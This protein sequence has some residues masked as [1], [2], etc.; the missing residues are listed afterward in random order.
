VLCSPWN[1][2]SRFGVANL[3]L[4]LD[5]P[6]WLLLV[7]LAV[8][9]VLA[10]RHRVLSLWGWRRDLSGALRVLAATGFAVAL[11]QPSL[12]VGD[13]AASV[14]IAVDESA[15]LTPAALA[16][17]Q[18]WIEQHLRVR[19]TADRV[20]LIAFAGDVR[21]VQPLTTRDSTPRLPDPA[22]LHPERTNLEA[23]LRTA[24]AMLRG[25]S[26]PR[27]I[28]LSDG[29]STAGDVSSALSDAGDVPVDVVPLAAPPRTP[30]VQLE[31]VQTPPYVR[32]GE[33][34]DS[35]VTLDATQPTPAHLQVAVDGQPASEQDVQL[36]S[37]QNHVTV[38]STE[39]D[40]GFHSI[41]VRVSGAPDTDA[42]NNVGFAFTVVKPKPR[43]MVI[44]E[45][46]DEGAAIE[47]MLRRAQM[48]VDVRPPEGLG[49]LDNLNPTAAV[50]LNNV[51]ATSLTLDQQKTL[52]SY[53]SNSGRGLVVLGGMTSYALG[54][55]SE[56]TLED[57]LPVLAQPP[58]KREGAQIAL[59]LV[60]DRSASM[61]LDSGG[62]TRLGMAKEAAILT[63]GALKPDDI[64][65]VMAF[66]RTNHWLVRPDSLQHLSSQNISDNISS[67]TAEGGTGLFQALK[68]AD[69]VLRATPADLKEMVLVDDGQAEDVKYD[70]LV[71]K[72]HQDK[73]GLSIVSMGDDV[74]TALMSKLARMGEGR[75]YQTARLRDIP[76][77][78]TQEA[79]LAK[80]A[81]LVEGTIQ[82]QLLTPSPM[83]RGIVPSAIPPLSG[84]IA[85]TPK[86]AAEVI[87]ASDEGTPLLAQWHYGL[88]RAV[89]WTSDVGT[90]W[91]TGWSG[92]DQNARFW[93]Q[94]VRWAMG[95]PIDR[96]F[97]ID[98]TRVGEEAHLTFEDVQDS[99]F[100]DR[101][102]L[103]LTVTSPDGAQSQAPLRQDAAGRYSATIL[104]SAPGAY[105]MDV[106]E[107]KVARTASRS[108]T[109]GFVVPPEAETVSFVAN[110]QVLRRIASETGGQLR[111]ASSTADMYP[112]DRATNA[113]RWDP[114]WPLFAVLALAAF[115][116]DVAVRRLRPSTLRALLGRSTISRGD[117][118]AP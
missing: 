96:D 59:V 101:Q 17:A 9:A 95:P 118:I 11:A 57:V 79:A 70:D 78:I 88:G 46:P 98:V 13:D 55:Y 27:V 29:Q 7:P 81:A 36:A 66:D 60:I 76:R 87:L 114:V 84:Q 4:R 31:S 21:I 99:Q 108:E 68:E 45:R 47:N 10:T 83:L 38:S 62:V 34:F 72:I 80:R 65:G 92:W 111:D 24:T 110:E 71:S 51:S 106:A 52:Q 82:P 49:T 93:E 18:S 100:A 56:T 58:E 64:L 16:D 41:A 28:L 86:D 102:K 26:N 113:S 1:G 103:T 116:L 53:V 74:D 37:G 75:F 20:G 14:V 33:T 117:T 44:E 63:A 3:P 67:L 48:T 112:A 19:R 50:I 8:L 104:A 30:E 23:A 12:R 94:V 32:V 73:I 35:T 15:S 115:V 5:A 54:G 91:S 25:S 77:I 107:P 61:G 22:L 109:S 90:R 97:K 40:E 43:V 85:T 6:V 69:D 105:E 42:S 2:Q 89:A 39:L